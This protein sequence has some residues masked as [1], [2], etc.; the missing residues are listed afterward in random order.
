[1]TKHSPKAQYPVSQSQSGHS[2]STVWVVDQIEEG[3]A[4][5]E[6]DGRAVI[7]VPLWILPSGVEE[8]DVLQSTLT[9]DPAEQAR[10]LD[11]SRDQ[12]SVRSKGD[13]GGDVVL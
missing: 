8:G 10:R 13:R 2:R 5:V 3:M 7:H 4:A 6:V 9:E 12:V 1:M 11:R